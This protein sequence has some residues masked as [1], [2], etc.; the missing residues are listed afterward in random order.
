M[1][2]T[3]EPKVC[4]T[5][6]KLP[7]HLNNFRILDQSMSDVQKWLGLG[8]PRLAGHLTSGLLLNYHIT[9]VFVQ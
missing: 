3:M 6:E 2:Q 1:K 8:I 4:L 9:I 7:K 5:L